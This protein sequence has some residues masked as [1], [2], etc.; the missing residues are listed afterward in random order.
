MKEI[1]VTQGEEISDF[2]VDL[3][4]HISFV[5]VKGVS[6]VGEEFYYRPIEVVTFWGQLSRLS[7]SHKFTLAGFL[8]VSICA[9]LAFVRY[10]ARKGYVRI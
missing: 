6:D 3:D 5:G 10:N 1:K 7:H 8:L 9:L 4:D 2:M